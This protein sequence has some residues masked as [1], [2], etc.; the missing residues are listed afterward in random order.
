[1]AAASAT[2]TDHTPATAE[3][4]V[5][6]QRSS[7]RN[8]KSSRGS[9]KSDMVRLTATTT[10]SGRIA[11][12]LDGAASLRR[13][14]LISA[15]SNSRAVVARS[16]IFSSLA[17]ASDRDP[18]HRRHKPSPAPGGPWLRRGCSHHIPKPSMMTE[19]MMPRP[20]AA[21][22]VVPKNG[23]GIAFWIDGVP[24]NAD[25]VKVEVPSTI[26]AGIRR[27]GMPAARNSA[28]AIGASTKKAT[29]RLTPPY[30]TK[31][32]ASTTASI[33]R[34]LAETLGHEIRDRGHRAAVLHELAEQRAEQKQRKE[35]RQKTRGAA[36]EDLCPIGKQRL[37]RRTP[38]RS[39]PPP[40][41]AAR[42]SSR[43]RRAK[44]EDQARQGC[45]A[46]PIAPRPFNTRQQHIEI[47]GRAFADIAAVCVEEFA[48][49]AAPLVSQHG[50]ELP[51][52]IELRGRAEFAPACRS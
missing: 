52:G 39:V 6:P 18:R 22:G 36:H 21:N 51:F 1:M 15:G 12:K 35:L 48:R 14:W 34:L 19:A 27:R 23:I 26:A 44:R 32:P 10:T 29:N 9:T 31:A 8:E 46:S 38:R 20:G 40:A 25:M 47:G 2:T 33:A 24:G 45:R 4:E 50:H 11:A 28:C 43:E 42:R 41:Q 5:P 7:A 37:A 3:I 17:T 16:R 49:G 30:V 13:P